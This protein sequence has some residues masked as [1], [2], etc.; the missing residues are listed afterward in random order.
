MR[1][2]FSLIEL[3]IVIAII[4]IIITVSIPA[5]NKA[6][7]LAREMA[8]SKAVQTIQTAEVMYQS[9][10][11]HYAQVLRELGPPDGG[12]SG[13]AAAG[14][15]SGALSAGTVGGYRFTLSATPDTF[16]IGASPVA[17]GSSG[18]KSFYLDQTGILRASDGPQPA[19]STSPEFAK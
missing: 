6:Q 7:M 17:Y 11:G 8:A 5:Y 2:G 18:V 10:Y 3:L 1:R 14:L 9:S 13:M 19:T 16:A 15:I 12:A 4:L